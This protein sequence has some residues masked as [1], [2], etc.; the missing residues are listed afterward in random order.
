MNKPQLAPMPAGSSATGM[1][2]MRPLADRAFE[3]TAGAQLVPGNRVRILKDAAENF[4]AW[5]EA[6]RAAERTVY[7]E[8]YIIGNDRVGREFVQAL[9]ER[10][11]AGVR[12]RL[13]Y[14]WLGTR[15][16]RSL[17]APLVAAGGAVRV[18]NPPRLDSPIG[19]LTRDHRKSIAVDG[20]VGFVSGLCAS[21]QWLGD[22]ARK[23]DAWR[24][25]GVEI[26]GP[27]VAEIERAFAQV[28]AACG[29]DPIGPA[30][31]TPA[32]AI[33]DAGDV[34]LRVIATV[35]NSG[36][37]LRLD[38]LIAAAAEERLWLTDA[39]F[40]GVTPYVQA[41][42]A[43]ARDDVDVR[44]L[45]PGA[46]DL[47]VVSGISRAAYRSL[48]EGGVRVFEWNGSMLHA[49]SAVADER[50]TRVGSTN[51]NIAS[52]LTNYELDV[53]IE[54][55]RLGARMAALYEEDLGNA[56]EI[57]LGKRYR[58]RASSAGR[59][60]RRVLSGSAGRAA[61]GAMGV[62]AAVGAALTSRRSLG[63]AEAN[64][65]GV[66]ALLLIALAVLAVLWP[67]ALAYPIA[68]IAAWAAILMLVRARRLWRERR[69]R[70]MEASS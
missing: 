14:D 45:V 69:K 59:H 70:T 61:A 13:L 8:S 67:P 31:L 2:G 48:L 49:K 53:A 65:L 20:R 29:G 63:P 42:C 1:F 3:R 68:V 43:A 37:L 15:A 4:P 52:W 24:D 41:L 38:Q 56:T 7:F 11:R 62:G 35:P 58:V 23:L 66:V 17:F 54:D 40:V 32:D 26:R 51:L 12:V 30:E 16:S 47:P 44:L 21:A 5:L 28:W 36:G 33:A 6:I 34:S 25:T 9:A 55:E 19:W 39:Y 18:F 64:L 57:V 27:A 50:W 60:G 22:P 10:A 46:S